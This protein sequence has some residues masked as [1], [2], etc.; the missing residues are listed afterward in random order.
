MT[1]DDDL[2]DPPRAHSGPGTWQHPTRQ[3][4]HRTG[5][6]GHREGRWIATIDPAEAADDLPLAV[7]GQRASRQIGL[8]QTGR[9]A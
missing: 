5:A 3:A 7:A 6:G 4:V 9:A 8:R 2:R 1:R